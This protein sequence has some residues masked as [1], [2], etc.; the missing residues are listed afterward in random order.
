MAAL[1]CIAAE[2]LF[3]NA[4]STKQRKPTIGINLEASGDTT[5]P[6]FSLSSDYVDAVT[7]AGGVPLLLP[8]LTS[9]EDVSEHVKLCDGFVFT[10]GRDVNPARFGQPPHAANKLL[11]PR[12]ENYDFR[13]IQEVLRARKPFLGVCLGCQQVNVALGGTLVQDIPSE[14]SSTVDHHQG[15]TRHETAHNVHIT[16]RSRLA[17]IVGTTTLAVNSIH[18]QSCGVPGRGVRYTAKSEDGII[19]GFEVSGSP[20]GIAVQWHPEAIRQYPGH[21]R[22]YKRLVQSARRNKSASVPRG[23]KSESLPQ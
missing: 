1:S 23:S 18:H 19:E 21:L 22:L 4:A 12:R 3:V 20:F 9:L 17:D 7:S 5:S 6:R 14:T 16:T 11:L 15:E 13:L 2:C 10:G 8:A